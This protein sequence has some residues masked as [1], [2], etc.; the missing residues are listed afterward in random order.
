MKSSCVNFLWLK[1]ES[2][3]PCKKGKCGY[4]WSSSSGLGTEASHG[5][6]EWKKKKSMILFSNSWESTKRFFPHF[7]PVEL[8]SIY[9]QRPCK[10][11]TRGIMWIK[12]HADNNSCDAILL[13]TDQNENNFSLLSQY[14]SW[15]YDMGLIWSWNNFAVQ[16]VLHGV[17]VY[18]KF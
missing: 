10:N 1:I 14:F 11:K 13:L 16:F 12:L 15:L 8:W 3:F 6:T 7:F 2:S 9:S 5:L 17:G 18:L 4:P